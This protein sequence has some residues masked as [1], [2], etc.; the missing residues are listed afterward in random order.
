M[1]LRSNKKFEKQFEKLPS[2]IQSKVERVIKIFSSNPFNKS[3]NNHSLKG[4][5]QNYRAI[6]VTGNIRIIF[7]E[8]DN[9]TLVI[10]ID[11]GTH[12]QV[13]K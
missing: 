11:L 6:S 4:Y 2:N 13:Y 7:E 3:L 8:F 12:E 1:I 9:Y 5:L 10:F